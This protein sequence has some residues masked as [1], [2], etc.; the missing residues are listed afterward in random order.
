[1]FGELFWKKTKWP[2]NSFPNIYWDLGRHFLCH[3]VF[4]VYIRN[5]YMFSTTLLKIC[6]AIKSEPWSF[7]WTKSSYKLNLIWP[8]FVLRDLLR[9][10]NSNLQSD[11]FSNEASKSKNIWLLF[12]NV[13]LVNSYLLK[14][15]E[16]VQ[17]EKGNKS[18]GRI[19]K[20]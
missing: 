1:M 13:N 11:N 20:K 18:P 2:S 6:L 10:S 3:K 16:N 5:F 7:K 14:R 8:L 9:S 17:I 12:L 19:W 15:I 4:I